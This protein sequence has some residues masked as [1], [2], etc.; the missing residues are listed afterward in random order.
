MDIHQLRDLLVQA[1]WDQI[2]KGATQEALAD[3]FT[4]LLVAAGIEEVAQ[5][6][7]ALARRVQS[8]TFEVTVAGPT[9]PGTIEV[10]VSEDLLN[11]IVSMGSTAAERAL[12]KG[13]A[14]VVALREEHEAVRRHAVDSVREA[15]Q[16]LL[17]A[18]E[19]PADIR[20]MMR[21]Y[22]ESGT[23]DRWFTDYRRWRVN[24]EQASFLSLQRV[25]LK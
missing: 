15:R 2:D 20:T 9:G 22:I 10:P 3:A 6:T 8:D 21:A 1:A 13:D 12:A 4:P 24:A 18:P 7:T 11:L 17:N 5:P 16:I 25:G 19:P 23:L 14:A